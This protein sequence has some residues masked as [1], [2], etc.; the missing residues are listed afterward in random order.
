[1]TQK[2]AGNHTILLVQ[3]FEAFALPF[4]AER[5]NAEAHANMRFYRPPFFSKEPADIKMHIHE[6]LQLLHS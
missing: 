4:V 3:Q 2:S 1:M 6:H 5:A